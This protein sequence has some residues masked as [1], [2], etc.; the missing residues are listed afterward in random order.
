M[1]HLQM[2]LIWVSNQFICVSHLITHSLWKGVCPLSFYRIFNMSYTTATASIDPRF[3][4]VEIVFPPFV[5]NVVFC[6]SV[7]VS[8][9]F[10]FLSLYCLLLLTAS[11][12]LIGTFKRFQ[13][14]KSDQIGNSP[15][16]HDVTDGIVLESTFL[17]RKKTYRSL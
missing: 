17:S 3:V 10:F 8:L 14:W 15:I 4:L 1:F 13:L 16:E 11:G 12:Y 7:L 5:F 2:Y 9:S 6:W